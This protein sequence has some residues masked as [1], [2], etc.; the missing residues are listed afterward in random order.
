[1]GEPHSLK[2]CPRS[3]V[4]RA[5]SWGRLLRLMLRCMTMSCRINLTP[6]LMIADG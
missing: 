4:S 3:A 1:M 6:K 5:T 2:N